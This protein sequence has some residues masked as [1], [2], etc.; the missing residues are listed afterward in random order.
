MIVG[1]VVGTVVCTQKDL[2]L[3]GKKMLMVQ[4]LKIFDLTPS[5]SPFI[6][7]DAIGSGVGEVVM[8]VGGSSARLADDFSKVAVDQAIIGILD[9]IEIEGNIVFRK[10]GE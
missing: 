10:E 3:V 4:P 7:L 5:G 6:A 2:S 9:T 1:K 8:V